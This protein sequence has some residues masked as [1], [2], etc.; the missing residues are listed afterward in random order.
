MSAATPESEKTAAAPRRSR[1]RG[2][3]GLL[4]R[5]LAYVREHTLPLLLGGL[6]FT[7]FV[8]YLANRHYHGVINLASGLELLAFS[9]FCRYLS[10]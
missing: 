9:L 10:Y 7:F 3:K 5:L 1:P 4:L 8:V 6:V 2:I